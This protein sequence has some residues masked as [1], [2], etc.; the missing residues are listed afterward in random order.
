MVGLGT[1]DFLILSSP[2]SLYQ[3][4][5]RSFYWTE[6]EVCFI[7]LTALVPVEIISWNGLVS[8]FTTSRYQQRCSRVSHNLDV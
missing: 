7:M 2:L 8:T 4:N 6:E 1:S 3:H 5:T